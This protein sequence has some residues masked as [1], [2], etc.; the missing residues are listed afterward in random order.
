MKGIFEGVCVAL[1]TPFINNKIDFDALKILIE[2]NINEGVDAICILGTT[3][4]AS[5]ISYKEREKIIAV[6]KKQIAQRVKLI[7]GCGSNNFEVAKNYILQAKKYNV[8]G[9]LVVTPYYN[10]TTQKG[11]VIF[12]KKLCELGLPIIAYNVPSRTGLNIELKT[13]NSLCKIKNLVGIKE[14]TQDINRIIN[15]CKICSKKICV[16]SGEDNL[17]CIFYILGANGCISVTANCYCKNVKEIFDLA[18]RQ[19]IKKAIK[20]QFCLDKINEA[21]FLET[22]PVPIKTLLNEKGYIKNEVRLPLVEMSNKNK[23]KLLKSVKK[24][25]QKMR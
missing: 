5:T 3:G 22:N 24:Y 17:N 14:S 19:K 18:K 8:D 16:Y 25:N 15:L 23:N 7:V 12:Y 4:E 1:V 13:I 9:A 6:T 10:K 2:K 20:L 11:I 21:L